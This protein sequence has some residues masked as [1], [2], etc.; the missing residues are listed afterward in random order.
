MEGKIKGFLRST[1]EGKLSRKKSY[2]S[3][4]NSPNGSNTV[5]LHSLHLTAIGILPSFQSPKKTNMAN[6][7]K[8]ES[9]LTPV[10]LTLSLLMTSTQSKTPKFS[11]NEL[12]KV[13]KVLNHDGP[14]SDCYYLV[15]WKGYPNMDNS[16]V[17]A[18]DFGSRRPITTYW[19]KK[20]PKTKK[21]HKWC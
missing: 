3:L 16:W 10:A 20:Y 13:E 7:Q 4:G 19:G 6:G 12:F 1:A 21:R 8:S 11:S 9:V 17:A 5:S 14:P 15:K 18:K 2:N